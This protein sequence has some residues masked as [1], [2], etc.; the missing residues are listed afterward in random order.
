MTKRTA[1]LNARLLDP[2]NQ[3]DIVGDLLVENGK[4]TDFGPGTFKAGMLSPNQTVDCSGLCLSPGLFDIRVQV[5]EPGEE[6]KESIATASEAAAAGGVTAMCCLPNTH[7]VID[8]VSVLEFIARRA[9]EIKSVK[10]F[11]Y[12]TLTRGLEGQELTEMAL[13]S[14]TGAL[15]FTDGVKAVHD[16]L[17]L[18]RALSYARTFDLLIVQHPEDERLVDDGVMNE[19]EV[20][21]RL[22]LPGIP[23]VAEVMA[24]E[25]DLRI[26]SLTGGRYHAAHVSTA[27]AI[28]AIRKAKRDG[29]DVTCDTAPHY[30]ALNETAVG[31]YRTFAKVS[32]PLR[33]ET[34]RRAV[35]EGL[36]D[37]TIDIIA[38]DHAPHDEDSKRLPF[39]QAE[40]GI[41]GLET[42]LPLTLELYHNGDMSLLDA[43][44][45]VTS[46]PADLLGCPFGRLERGAPADLLIF[47]PDK[48]RQIDETTFRSKAKNAPFDMRPV[49]GV[50]RRTV[51]EGRTIY[52]A[53]A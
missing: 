9:R 33:D 24:I 52:E 21:T 16:P 51:V 11:C 14:E 13:L 36:A 39:V 10:L 28:D 7:P 50:V 19:G 42:L 45:K 41:I 46:K 49:Q 20:A 31:D 43:L 18:R 8:D 15:A 40:F 44:A 23:A 48:P 30:F 17:V 32:P 3:M 35:V 47:D 53:E 27:A 1:Y 26:L 4:I 6:H 22:G 12:G 5:R 34:D 2:A 25:R 29:Y 37:G 38:S